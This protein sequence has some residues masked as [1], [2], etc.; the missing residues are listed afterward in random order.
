MIISGSLRAVCVDQ[1]R[2]AC[3]PDAE[4]YMLVREPE[5]CQYVVTLYHP[6]HCSQWERGLHPVGAPSPVSGR[7]K[8]EHD[9]L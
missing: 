6:L 7:N 8:V 2:M 1:V 4:V 5:L 3:S 9:E